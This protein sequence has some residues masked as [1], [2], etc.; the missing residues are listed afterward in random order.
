MIRS[1]RTKR[2]LVAT[3]ATFFALSLTPAAFAASISNKP[4][5][6]SSRAFAKH[7][8]AV[9]HI[10]FRGATAKGHTT[11]IRWS[12]ANAG[13]KKG[14]LKITFQQQSPTGTLYD[15]QEF[16]RGTYTVAA[17]RL[18]ITAGKNTLA[19]KGGKLVMHFEFGRIKG[20]AVLSAGRTGPT[21]R[22]RDKTGW[23]KRQLL[24]AW[25]DLA[26]NATD[27]RGRTANLT[28][29]VFAVHDAS[30]IKAHRTY[31]RS[32]QLHKVRGKKM[33]VV[34]FI[35]A[36][37]ERAHRPLGFVILRGGMS[38][39]GKVTAERRTAVKVDG[40]NDYQ[41][42]YSIAVESKA[43]KATATVILAAKKRI[44]RR[45]DLKGLNWF[46]RKAVA[47]FIHPYTYTL[48]GE[49]QVALTIGP[50]MRSSVDRAKWKYAQARE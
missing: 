2:W 22:D 20:D 40:D 36:P 8:E 31:D 49:V 43:R 25:G 33:R 14:K 7:G 26:I 29:N 23:I 42:P 44:K 41:V 10:T 13:Y 45:D 47:V 28:S 38:Y 16:K 17:D 4:L 1:N 50:M 35:I 46:A 12:M 34:D 21:L 24:C 3:T 18:A 30:T 39:V 6:W 19:V 15:E 48:R 32:I 27:S 37:K 9:E 11:F 5:H